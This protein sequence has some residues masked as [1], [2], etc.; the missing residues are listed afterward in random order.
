[1]SLAIKSYSIEFVCY[2]TRFAE[3]TYASIAG[4]K[5]GSHIII[6]LLIDVIKFNHTF[7]PKRAPNSDFVVV[8][9]SL[10]LL[11]VFQNPNHYRS[12]CL[13]FVM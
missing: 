3:N 4:K 9:P 2:L 10:K 6:T 1:M 7:R 13:S 8:M 12:N 5:F 11:E